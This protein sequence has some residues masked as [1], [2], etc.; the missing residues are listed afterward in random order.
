[1]TEMKRQVSGTVPDSICELM[2]HPFRLVMEYL[3]NEDVGTIMQFPFSH[4]EPRLS[5]IFGDTYLHCPF[6]VWRGGSL[7]TI[8]HYRR[9]FT[10]Q[11]CGVYQHY[12]SARRLC[13][14]CDRKNPVYYPFKCQRC[15]ATIDGNNKITIFRGCRLRLCNKCTPYKKALSC[16]FSESPGVF[17]KCS[18]STTGCGM[19]LANGDSIFTTICD[20]HLYDTNVD[21]EGQLFAMTT[22]PHKCI[23]YSVSTAI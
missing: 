3:D 6:T 12:M 10:C 2:G 8:D 7:Q 5:Q 4:I 20:R 23:V 15:D 13:Q 9:V 1:M 16:I 22:S 11:K 14:E 18:R 19:R 21:D 17:G